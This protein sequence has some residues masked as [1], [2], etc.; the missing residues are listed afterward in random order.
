MWHK[1]TIM[2]CQIS[3]LLKFDS[4]DSLKIVDGKFNKENAK[5]WQSIIFRA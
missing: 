3:K 2:R 4:L 1:K 5:K